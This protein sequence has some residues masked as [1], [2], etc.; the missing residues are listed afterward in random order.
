MRDGLTELGDHQQ[1][2]RMREERHA[3]SKPHVHAF[4]SQSCRTTIR[5]SPCHRARNLCSLLVSFFKRIICL[6]IL[7]EILPLSHGQH[8]IASGVVELV[9]DF[10]S[11]RG[12]SC[13]GLYYQTTV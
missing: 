6:D 4:H 13:P 1:Y 5:G 11:D 3:L 8:G 9:R 12:R 10:W 2:L 7:F